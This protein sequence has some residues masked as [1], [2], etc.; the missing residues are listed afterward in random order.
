MVVEGK[1]ADRYQARRGPARKE[2]YHCVVREKNYAPGARDWR[3]LALTRCVP[4]TEEELAERMDHHGRVIQAV[5]DA[6]IAVEDAE[7][8][9]EGM[10]YAAEAAA[11]AAAE[12]D[13]F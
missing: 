11:V 2:F 10:L 8:R 4:M 5:I 1:A 9:E 7:A 12:H 13:L 6:I 3:A